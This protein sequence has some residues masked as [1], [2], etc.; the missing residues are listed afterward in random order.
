MSSLEQLQ[1]G[2][3]VQALA[4]YVGAGW[5]VLQMTETVIGLLILPV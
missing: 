5:V 1:S 4:G 2:R 3:M